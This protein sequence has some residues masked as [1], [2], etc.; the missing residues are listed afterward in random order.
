MT[1]TA[2]PRHDPYAAL[3]VG[4]TAKAPAAGDLLFAGRTSAIVLSSACDA[5]N[6]TTP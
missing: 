2:A 1:P 4:A 6:I 3:R 5:K